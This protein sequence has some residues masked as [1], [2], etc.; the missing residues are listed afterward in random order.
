MK[1]TPQAQLVLNHLDVE[2]HITGG[3]AYLVYGIRSLSRRITE[4]QDAG[5]VITKKLKTDAKGQRYVRYSLD[6]N[7]RQVGEGKGRIWSDQF[8]TR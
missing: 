2:D 3:E 5:Y 8:A 7:I 1:L 4:L 6:K